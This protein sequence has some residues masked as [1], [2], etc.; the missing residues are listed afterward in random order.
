MKS[1]ANQLCPPLLWSGLSKL[2][3]KLTDLK[4]KTAQKAQN[5]KKDAN[6]EVQDLDLYWDPKMANLLETWGE[7]NVWNEVQFLMA[8]LEGK[9]LDIACGTGRTMEIL[10][11][12]P[13]LDLYG[14]DISDLLIEKAKQRGFSD[15][16]L[17]ISDATATDYV[18]DSFDYS[19]S[20]GSL[21]H[22][23]ED[24]I[25]KFIAEAYRITKASSFHMLPVSRSNQNE[26]WMKTLQS[27]HNNSIEWWLDK[28]KQ[29]YPNVYVLDSQW[30]DDISIG[31]WFICSKEEKPYF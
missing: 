5:L 21:E 9:V 22:F 18:D 24:G 4:N 8:P 26:G 7:G 11:K 14:V 20:I 13:H 31:K 29:A 2:K 27:F 1:I 10:S 15:E 28:F 3:T 17:K 30:N 19:Y 25:L 12:F 23:T 6:P 16:K